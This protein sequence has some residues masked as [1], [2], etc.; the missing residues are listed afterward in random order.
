M[1]ATLAEAELALKR[2]AAGAQPASLESPTLDFKEDKPSRADMERIIADAAICFA[3]AAGGILAV[4]V[5]DKLR[6]AAALAGTDL[7]PNI[8]RQRVF[9]L[10]SPPLNVEVLRYRENPRILLVLVPESVEIHAD[11]RGRA[12]H[13]INTNCVP[14]MPGDYQRLREEKQGLDWSALPTDLP[15]GAIDGEALVVARRLL[16]RFSDER[17]LVAG[18]SD[19]DVLRAVG[20]LTPEG[21]VTRA[22]AL[23]FW[24][25]EF[26]ADEFVYQYRATPGGEP[27][28]VSRLRSPLVSTFQRLMDLVEARQSITPITLPNG[29]QIAL[30]D[31]PV[32]AVREVISNAICHRD[33]HRNEPCTI[34]HSPEVFSVTSPGP[35]V[36]GVTLT[37]ILTT[38]SR[39]RNRALT[40]IA[41][42]LG[43]AEELGRGIDRIY[44]ELI[45]GGREL[46]HIEAEFDR[47][48]LTF[49][50]GAINTQI[51]RFFAALPDNERDDT[52]T[53]LIIHQ[54]C[55]SKTV[56]SVDL[57]GLLQ[58]PEYEIRA[59][60][61]RLAN[62]EIGLVE[63]TRATARLASPTY[64]LRANAL[65]QLGSAVAYL[66]RTTDDI[67]RKIIAHLHEYGKITNRT[68]QNMLDVHVFKSRDII[69]DLVE[70]GML[71]RISEQTRGPKVEWG[72]GPRCPQPKSHS[73]RRQRASKDQDDLFDK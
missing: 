62:D 56:S 41:R 60:L 13:R 39:P 32:L 12:T 61:R 10:T 72:A 51:A 63:P 50:G 17:R 43:L 44:R 64:R 21:R 25:P 59:I 58:K 37:N 8:V 47:V 15:L 5:A 23:M 16:A 53:M 73:P 22:G 24:P 6:G 36:S 48:R 7:D 33:Y 26:A 57:A 52:D 20:A 65:R 30:A 1:G 69:S 19:V 18:Q 71:V 31:F 49:V 42:A 11:N 2:I 34:E 40:K 54:L 38:S 3:N 27:R 29:Q 45:K 55:A 67:D 9:E 35:L 28:T 14:V 66:R 68:I 46:P 70:R 4:G